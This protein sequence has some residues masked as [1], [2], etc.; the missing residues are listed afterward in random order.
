MKAETGFPDVP[1]VAI[2]RDPEHSIN[3]LKEEGIPEEEAIMFEKLWHQLVAEQASLSTQGRLMIAKN[4][5][6]SVDAD[7]PDLVIEVIKSLL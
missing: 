7:R 3:F 2:A 1:L 4:S 5:S 6:H